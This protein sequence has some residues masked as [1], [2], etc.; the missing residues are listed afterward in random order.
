MD[1]DDLN[2]AAD[3]LETG[4]QQPL[5]LTPLAEIRLPVDT[6]DDM[7]EAISGDES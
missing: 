5:T 4:H 1:V 2:A 6:L 3:A 7:R